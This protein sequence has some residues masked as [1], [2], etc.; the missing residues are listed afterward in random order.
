MWAFRDYSQNYFTLRLKIKTVFKDKHTKKR[1]KGIKIKW[2]FIR[3]KQIS[4]IT[5]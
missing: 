5:H 2:S 1:V 4:F 3:R